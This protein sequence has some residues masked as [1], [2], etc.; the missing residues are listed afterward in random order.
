MQVFAR[1]CATRKIVSPI[2]K[3]QPTYCQLQ[4]ACSLWRPRNVQEEYDRVTLILSG[5]RLHIIRFSNAHRSTTPLS[6]FAI[7]S[8]GLPTPGKDFRT[9]TT[10]RKP[11]LT[12]PAA[13]EQGKTG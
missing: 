12:K 10:R 4:A 13:T 3:F 5:P 11:G 2:V 1:A 6:S 8:P 7:E 9:C